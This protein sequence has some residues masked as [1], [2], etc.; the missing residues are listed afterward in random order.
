MNQLLKELSGSSRNIPTSY[1]HISIDRENKSASAFAFLKW[2][3]EHGGAYLNEYD[4]LPP[5]ATSANKDQVNSFFQAGKDFSQRARVKLSGRE[6][7]Y[8]FI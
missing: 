2:V 1:L 6:M 7:I 8:L 5:E 3:A 4:F